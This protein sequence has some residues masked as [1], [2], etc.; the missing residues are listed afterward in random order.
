MRLIAPDWLEQRMREL[1]AGENYESGSDRAWPVMLEGRAFRQFV[2][3]SSFMVGHYEYQHVATIDELGGRITP[4]S[5]TPAS[6]QA[7]VPFMGD[8]FTFGVG[9]EDNET[10]VS[11][12]AAEALHRSPAGGSPPRLLNLGMTGTALHNQLDT[13]ELRHDELG[14]PRF[15]VFAMFMGN[16][17]T[18]I[19]RHYRRSASGAPSAGGSPGRRWLW[20]A[21]IFVYHH[22]LLKKLYAIQ[23]LRQKLLTVIQMG[24]G[25]G[26]GFMDPVFQAMRKDRTYLDEALVFFRHEL[27]R[28]AEISSRLGFE[29]VFLLIPDVH[30]LDA[31]RLAGKAR[32]LGLDLEQLAPERITQAV[33]R[34]LSDFQIPYFDVGPCLSAAPIEGLYY[35]QD[36]HLTAAGHA[37]AARCILES[38]LLHSFTT[39]P[40]AIDSRSL[41]SPADS[42]S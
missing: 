27:A 40:A 8:S 34:A 30:Q 10:F 41:V 24:A 13:L 4:F 32:S 42:A 7:F 39:P 5:S 36:T 3:G 28:L 14:G 22:P 18:N 31:S 2:P 6:D 25:R 37:L 11:L 17:L 38:G 20:Q 16:D 26:G 21:N 23:F 35:T 33:S 1:N 15:Y 19:A 9:V 29:Y 12:I